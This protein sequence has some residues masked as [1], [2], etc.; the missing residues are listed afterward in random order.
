MSQEAYD[1]WRQVLSWVIE[2]G[3]QTIPKILNN[4]QP[5]PHPRA[6]GFFVH[7]V[8]ELKGQVA[9]WRASL[10]GDQ[11]GFHAVEFSNRYECHL[12][13]KD[14]LK[15]PVGHLVEDSPG[16]LVAIAVGAIATA[17]IVGGIAY[18]YRKKR[19]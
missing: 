9:D 13:K 3:N 1:F 11:R 10:N 16:T 15:D 6:A 5:T 7:H 12:D 4:G 19:Q 14:A 2:D 18:Y 17:A 8:G